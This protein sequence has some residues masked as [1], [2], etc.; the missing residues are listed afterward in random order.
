MIGRLSTVAFGA[1]CVAGAAA[2]VGLTVHEALRTPPVVVSVAGTSRAGLTTTVTISVRNTTPQ[3]RCV[4]LRV[5]ARTRDGRDL[6][7]P[8]VQRAVA[9]SPHGHRRTSARITLTARQYAEQLDKF[10]PS[11]RACGTTQESGT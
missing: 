6:G 11:T 10:Y 1:F 8:A 2:S 9:L 5:A 7:K 4:D 3:T